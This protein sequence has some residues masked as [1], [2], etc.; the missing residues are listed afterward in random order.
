[1]DSDAV[2]A[3]RVGNF[4]LSPVL[5]QQQVCGELPPQTG[6][7]RKTSSFLLNNPRP[8]QAPLPNP[9]EGR[10]GRSGIVVNSIVVFGGVG[11]VGVQHGEEWTTS[12]RNM[13]GWGTSAAQRTIQKRL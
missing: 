8:P 6:P 13:E 11:H 5:C 7:Q 9:R 10:G 12:V 4:P 2:R 3:G 1:M